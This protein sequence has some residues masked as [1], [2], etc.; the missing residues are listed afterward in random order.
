MAFNKT[1]QEDVSRIN[2]FEGHGS[3]SDVSSLPGLKSCHGVT[4]KAKKS[5]TSLF[6]DGME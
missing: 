2:N 4:S 5:F 6:R 1:P 3:L